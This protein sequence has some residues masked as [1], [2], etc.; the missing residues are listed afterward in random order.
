[1]WLIRIALRRPYTFV[2]MALVIALGGGYAI[3]KAPTDIFPT[4]DIPVISVIWNYGG[5]PPEEMEKRIVSNFER[6][7]TTIVADIEHIESQTLTGISIVKVFLQPGANVAQAIAQI[8]AV[9]QSAVRSMPPGVVPPLIMRY[10]ATSVPIMQIALE[11]DSLSEQQLFDYGINYIRAEISTIPGV[12]IPFPFGGKQRQIMVD[13]DPPKLASYGLSA[14]DIQVALAAQNVVLPSGTAKIGVNEYP[15]VVSATPETLEEL[16]QIPLRTVNGTTVYLRDVANVRDGSSPQTNLVHV[17]GQRSVLMSIMKNGDA[18]TLEVTDRIYDAIPRALDRLPADARG[19]VNVKTLFDQSVFVRAAI[20]GVIHE[21]LIAGAL[22]AVMILIF[23]GSWRST[24]TVVISIPLSILFSISVLYL[25]GHTLNV[26]TLGGLALAVGILVDD[27]TVAIENI[28]RNI[29]QRKPFVQAIVDGAQQIAMPALVSTL[30]ICIVFF[31][32]TFLSGA[33]KSLFVPLGLAVVLAMMM[34]YLLSRTLVPTMVRYL[35]AREAAHHGAPNRFAAAFDRAFAAFRT[36]YGRWL[37][38]A[39]S[40]RGTVVPAFLLFVAGSLAMLPLVG[41]DF[42]PTVDAGLIKLHVRGAPGMRLEESEKQIAAIQ[43]TIREVIPPGEIETMLDVMGTPYSGINLSLSEG[44]LISPADA[45][46]LIA[47]GPEHGP[48][49]QHVRALRERLRAQF[50]DTTFFFLAPDIST[51]VLNFG[52]AAPI[53][54]QV[55]GPIGSEDKTLAFTEQIAARI[56]QVPGAVDVHLAQ[57]SNVPQLK[58]S[59]D[60]TRAQQGGATT[61]DVASDLLVSLASSGSVSPSYWIDKRGVQYL[62]AVQTPQ[63]AIDS[64]DALR[65]TPISSSGGTDKG[66]VSAQTLGNL[67]SIKRATG[68]ANITHYN[69]ARTFDVQAN[70]EGTDLGSVV[71]AVREILRDMKPPPGTR[72]E[73]KGQAESMDSSF[74]GLSSG[75][76]FAILL[77][78]LLLVVNFQSWL[79][80]FIILMALPGALAGIVWALFLTGTT[81]SV[82]A[83]IGSIMCVGVATANSILVVSFANERRVANPDARAAALAA[84]MTRLRPVI[85][86]ASAMVLGMMPM[87][88]GLGEGGEQNAPLGRAVIGGLVL[89]TAT[90][91]F[92]VPVMY[93]LLR[94]RPPAARELDVL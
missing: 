7:T 64:I 30:C 90:T 37:A 80:P 39:L 52:L 93:S 27:A 33:S 41:R 65:A 75:L 67:A 42:F 71:D 60:R 24:L 78:Y 66:G 10:S 77:V 44:A 32:I 81:L 57:V 61:R 35:L 23:L 17:E 47:L 85:M 76:V 12:Q 40:R 21:A 43:Q 59:V 83:L 38:W 20:D 28:H 50:R 54:V 46:I 56:A 70:V 58:I 91:L 53:D 74:G 69:I 92:F 5:L 3:R 49:A 6:F 84:G 13:L 34:S 62:V 79:D 48:T 68:P 73:L 16:S 14:R 8:T 72:V 94:R 86:T 63:Y 18:S 31:P 82:P 9:A 2:V 11:S 88:I 19:K 29:G 26:M 22:T 4:I 55:V 1:M 45:Q 36:V 87:A 51:Q 25:L 15:I 89:A